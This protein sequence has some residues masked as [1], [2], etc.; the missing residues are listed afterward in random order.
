MPEITFVEALRTT[1]QEEMHRDPSLML[2]GEDIGRYGGIFGVT[3]GLLDTFGPKRVRNTPIS[4]STIVGSALGAAMTGVRTVAELMYVDF[5]TC[6]MDQLVNQVAKMHYMSGG[7]LRIPLVIRTHGGGGRGNAAQ[8]SQNLEAWFLH[9]PGLKV[10]MPS[11]PADAKGLLATAIREDN[12]VL[13]IEHKLLYATKGMVPEGEHL[14]PLG[15]ADIK[16]KGKDVTIVTISHMV[17]KALQAAERL[18][19]EGIEAEV[20]DLRTLTPLDLACVLDS[21]RKTNRVVIAHEAC[22]RGGFGGELAAQI[23][24][25]AFDYL[26]APIQR[27]GS[28]DVPIPYSK[29][30][31]EYVIPGEE[32]IIRAA[33]RVLGRA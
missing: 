2:I 20:I 6:A 16:R 9:V 27:V 26:D 1:L 7:K 19:A 21:V 13:F 11:T 12:P 31:E 5:T 3:K 25:E 18:A 24:E 15:Q 22:R 30:M 14:I 10:V 28:L 23:Q 33:K 8:H 32:A 17:L 29:P 4:E